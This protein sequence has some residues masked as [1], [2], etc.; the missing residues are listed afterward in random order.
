MLKAIISAAGRAIKAAFRALKATAAFPFRLLGS[1]GGGGAMPPV[2][3]EE[4]AT[5]D[6]E[7]TG[8]LAGIIMS[9]AVGC[10]RTRTMEQPPASLPANYRAWL[11]QLDM[12][13]A[14]LLVDAG[15]MGIQA[16]ISGGALQGVPPADMTPS[17][18]PAWRQAHAAI[19]DA[20]IGSSQRWQK[21]HRRDPAEAAGPDARPVKRTPAP[22]EADDEP[23]YESTFA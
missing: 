2:E 19:R 3:H 23:G 7:D 15:R 16:H 17:V 9:W 6:A 14:V 18:I 10:V 21:L 4:P 22:A 12:R 13:E 11:E 8:A 1:L 20:K 5:L